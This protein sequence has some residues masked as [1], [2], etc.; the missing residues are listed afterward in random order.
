MLEFVFVCAAEKNWSLQLFYMNNWNFELKNFDILLQVAVLK[1][2][3]DSLCCEICIY[4]T[5]PIYR[6]EL[7]E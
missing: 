6:N 5:K 2:V 4:N 1:Y 3:L 7:C